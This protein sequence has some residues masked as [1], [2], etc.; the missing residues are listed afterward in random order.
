MCVSVGLCWWIWHAFH[1]A[2]P[3]NVEPTSPVSAEVSSSTNSPTAGQQQVGQATSVGKGK[4]DR[5]A[6][7]LVMTSRTPISFYGRVVDQHHAPV[8][9][10]K[11][12]ASV[13]VVTSFMQEHREKYV[14]AT[15]ADGRFQYVGLHGQDLAINLAKEGY[16]FKSNLK[17]YEYSG[18][19]PENQRHH[20]D[21][22]A[23]VIFEMWK[24]Q[25][26]VPL[27]SGDKF[28]KVKAD[29]SPFTIDL[30]KG[31]IHEGRGVEGDLIV[32]V[33]QPPG[34]ARGTHFD[35]S[36]TVEAI[37]EGGVE[38]ISSEYPNEAP[39]DGY[40]AQIVCGLKANDGDWSNVRHEKFFVKSRNGNQYSRVDVDV[41]ANYQGNAAL[42]ISYLVN[43]SPGSRNLEFDPKKRITG[44]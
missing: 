43:P 23:P 39:L 26:S 30:M 34:V 12:E 15:D 38:A 28:F 40:R 17:S 22:A 25:G 35:W 32:L 1:R 27:I 8:S 21:P 41:H 19:T 31:S 36:F 10:V 9:G 16:Q 5:A 24:R 7:I 11:V 18:L 29:G 3:G 13:H 14:T 20:P 4:G 2:V 42:S 6:E 44:Q 37:G 33:N